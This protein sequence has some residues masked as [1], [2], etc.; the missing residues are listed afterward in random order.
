MSNLASWITGLMRENYEA[1][2]F[3]PEPT[4]TS[5]Y[6]SRG[7]Y[8]LQ[9]DERGQSV[10]YLLHGAIHPGNAA[11][12]S[13]HVI[14][15]DK[16]LRGY[17]EQAF[18]VLLH[19]CRQ[20]NVASIHLRCADDLP[21]IQFWQALGFQVRKLTPGGLRRGRMIVEMFYPLDL[22]LFHYER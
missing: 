15:M 13:Q 20:A 12:I 17:G 21:S 18:N 10:G 19:R 3:I 8:V 7:R 4:V 11:Y 1:I 22:P 9:S 6:L 16:R 5:R 2:G 14:Q